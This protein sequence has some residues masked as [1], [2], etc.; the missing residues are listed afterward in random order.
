MG[1]AFSVLT[2]G[3]L[4]HPEGK[5]Q[6]RAVQKMRK[7]DWVNMRKA[8]GYDMAPDVFDQFAEAVFQKDVHCLHTQ[9][10][11]GVLEQDAGAVGL[12][13]GVEIMMETRAEGLPRIGCGGF[14][15]GYL[16]ADLS[17]DS[18]QHRFEQ[19]RLVAEPVVKRAA[20]HS[21]IRGE[22]I[23]RGRRK[24]RCGKGR[25]RH[26][27]QAVGSVLCGGRACSGFI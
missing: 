19:A 17:H 16:G 27:D 18:T 26:R 25:L 7:S 6:C 15:G 1:S 3:S 23:E 10:G 2:G 21:R 8:S 4:S 14:D 11:G 12:Q 13:D 24:A 20:R 9:H 22:R 5:V